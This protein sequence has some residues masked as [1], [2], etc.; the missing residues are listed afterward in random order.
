MDVFEAARTVLAIRRY[1]KRAV[2]DNV[3][4]RVVEAARLTGSSMNGQPWHFVV[5]RDR[6]TLRRLGG[7]LRTGPYVADAAVAVAVAVGKNSRFAVSDASRAIQSMIL[8]AWGDG[9]GSNWVG[10][11]GLHT[12]ASMLNLPE[13]Y[14]VLAMVSFGYPTQKRFLGRKNRK[15]LSTI[16]SAE[17]FGLPFE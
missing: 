17:R 12:V 8:T 15:P 6:D 7:A 11:G 5:V 9:V 10:F 4:H 3:V 16:V 14:D 1:Q 2:P 13:E